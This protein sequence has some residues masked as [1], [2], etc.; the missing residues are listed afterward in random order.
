M[1]PPRAW[2]SRL[3]PEGGDGFLQTSDGRE[4]YFH[5]NSVRHGD[6]DH[7]TVGME[8]RFAE[9]QGEKGP[10]ASTV[11]CVATHHMSDT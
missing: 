2:V 11:T 1:S 10:Q 3:F 5:R 9:E 8:V 4:I 6:F 7:L